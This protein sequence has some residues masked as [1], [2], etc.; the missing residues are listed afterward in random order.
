MIDF[1]GLWC[2]DKLAACTPAARVDYLWV[3]GIADPNG[4]FEI[5]FRAISSKVSILRP[6]LTPARLTK[7]FKEFERRGLLF[8]WT[9][10]GRKRYGYWT[11]SDRPGRLPP[12]AERKRY[13]Q[14]APPV[15]KEKLAAYLKRFGIALESRGPHE[16]VASTSRQGVGVGVGVGVGFGEGAGEGQGAHRDLGRTNGDAARV[17]NPSG[18]DKTKSRELR[19]LH[20]KVSDLDR[21]LD[22]N[23]NLVPKERARIEAERDATKAQLRE[24]EAK[25]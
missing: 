17:Q 14:F 19:A 24:L 18:Q 22:E 23:K 20:S 25:P 15:P 3:Y 9:G 8:C 16:E 5:N 11:G 13:R 10:D 7:S 2:S 12:K 21:S 6:E 1:D 4:C